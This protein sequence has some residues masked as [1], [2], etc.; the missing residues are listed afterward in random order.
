MTCKQ[1]KG[2]N[3]LCGGWLKIENQRGKFDFCDVECA[4]EWL[5]DV[6]NQLGIDKNYYCN[7][8]FVC[9]HVY[10]VQQIDPDTGRVFLNPN[11]KCNKHDKIL[12]FTQAPPVKCKECI[13]V[14]VGTD[15]RPGAYEGCIDATS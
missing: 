6:D 3:A 11:W 4:I 7:S 13:E 15:L 10:A 9:K 5:K 2:E 12:G 1:C 8:P 14:T